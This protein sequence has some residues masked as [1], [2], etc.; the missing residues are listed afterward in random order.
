MTQPK[1]IHDVDSLV[2]KIRDLCSVQKGIISI[3]GF[4]GSR[5]SDLAGQLCLKL[6]GVHIA[7][8]RFLE[9]NKGGYLSFL[10]YGELKEQIRESLAQGALVLVEGVCIRQ[11]LEKV[12]IKESVDI[13]VKEFGPG[14]WRDGVFLGQYASADEAIAGENANFAEYRRLNGKPPVPLPPL[15]KELIQY[16]Y[17]FQ[18]HE[19]AQVVFIYHV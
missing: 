5:K 11:V 9:R 8:D 16:H 4:D 19:R 10:R 15:R 7:V 17:A 14:G 12:C 6:P 2:K 13:Y 1:V 18:P 3:D